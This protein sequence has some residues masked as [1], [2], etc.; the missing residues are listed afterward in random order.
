MPKGIISEKN[1]RARYYTWQ[2]KTWNQEFA[3][4]IK[5]HDNFE[6][7]VWESEYTANKECEAAVFSQML[8]GEL[9]KNH[10]G[11]DKIEFEV[12][13]YYS[14]CSLDNNKPFLILYD[15]MNTKNLT[16]K[17]R[18]CIGNYACYPRL[19]GGTLQ[20]IHKWH[21]EDWPAFLNWLRD[22]W[23][24]KT[25]IYGINEYCQSASM[26]DKWGMTF[27]DYMIL[28][29]QQ[30]YYEEIYCGLRDN[31]FNSIADVNHIIGEKTGNLKFVKSCDVDFD[32]IIRIRQKTIESVVFK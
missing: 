27:E 8:F 26:K 24:K 25:V 16:P 3:E 32:Y 6:G 31:K 12:N 17:Q 30:M 22:N 21:N 14:V 29:C 15:V 13:S 23:D 10:F 7:V 19:E 9:F 5:K 2:Q 28:T 4:Y 1:N 20:F 11:P 18:H